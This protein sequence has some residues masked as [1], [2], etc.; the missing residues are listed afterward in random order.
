LLAAAL[1]DAGDDLHQ[2]Q[3]QPATFGRHT[4]EIAD[5]IEFSEYLFD[6]ALVKSD[7][8]VAE[9]HLQLAPP[10]FEGDLHPGV[11]SIVVLDG[12]GEQVHQQHLEKGGIEP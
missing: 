9:G 7:P 6:L 2:V 12:V 4:V 11:L 8:V 10:S 5:P 1:V 3:P